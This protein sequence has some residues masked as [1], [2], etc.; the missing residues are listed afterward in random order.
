MLIAYILQDFYKLTID[1]YLIKLD[2]SSLHKLIGRVVSEKNWTT[3][4]GIQ[5]FLTY[6]ESN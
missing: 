1:N 3:R 6:S 5:F 2:A 4:S